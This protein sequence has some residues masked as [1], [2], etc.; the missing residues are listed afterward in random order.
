MTGER[1]FR[2]NL[3]LI[4]NG[5]KPIWWVYGSADY[6]LYGLFSQTQTTACCFGTSPEKA[7]IPEPGAFG[8]GWQARYR[9]AVLDAASP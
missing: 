4:A 7:V 2:T 3:S 1:F 9:P 6:P 5:K 8:M